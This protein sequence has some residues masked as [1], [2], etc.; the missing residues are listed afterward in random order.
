MILLFDI[1][2]THT[3]VG[4]ANDRRV[5]RQTNIPTREWFG[6]NAAARRQK[7]RRRESNCR[8][9]FVQRRAPRHAAGAEIRS[10]A[11]EIGHV[12]ELTPETVRGV[13]ID[14]PKPNS[15]GPDRL[16]N[17]VAAASFWRAGGGGGFRHGGHLRRGE[18]ARAITS[19]ALSRR[20]WRR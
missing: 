1:G 7:I 16:A 8:R 5:V 18:C 17:A 19:A 9:G 11:L 4:L 13:G 20:A 14:Y 12:L 3:H 10:R 15:I 6:G 2:N